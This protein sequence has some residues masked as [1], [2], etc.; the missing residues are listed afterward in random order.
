MALRGQTAGFDQVMKDIDKLVSI[1][2][3]EQAD[4]DNK[5]SFCLNKIDKV[6]D[7]KKV[8][9]RDIEDSKTA[10][11]DSDEKIAA[12]VTEIKAMQDGLKQLSADVEEQTNLRKTE[13]ANNVKT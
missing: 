6:E 13:H 2:A 9:E 11:A 8:T 12:L 10:I 5:K 1:L 7:E 4:D 3:D